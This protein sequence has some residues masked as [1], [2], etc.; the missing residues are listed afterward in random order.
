MTTLQL[1]DLPSPPK[2]KTG[3][4]WT[5]ISQCPSISGN[6]K[7]DWPRITIVTP[8]YNQGQYIEE[9]IRSVLLQNYPNLEYLVIDG[10]STDGTLQILKK[11]DSFIRWI[12][13][14]DKGQTD[15]INKG[16]KMAT[17]EIMAY[18]NSDDLYEPNA[19]INIAAFFG[20]REEIAMIYGDIIHINEKSGFIEFHRTGKVDIRKYLMWDFYLP[21][22]SVFFRKRVIDT[23]GYFDE[24]LHLAMDYDYWLKIILNFETWYVPETLSRAR[25]YPQA[26]SSFLDYMYHD[27]R[28]A[29]LDSIFKKYD[30]EPYRKNVF[31]Y[32]YFSG[33]L[34]FMKRHHIREAIKNFRIA[35]NI[36]SRYIIHPYLYWGIIE[37]IIGEKNAHGFKPRLKKI[38]DKIL[39]IESYNIIR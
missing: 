18:L 21:Q 12:S 1:S 19:L 17:G 30:F 39:H 16:L 9:T 6:E 14:P 27:E 23:L 8:S 10:N 20:Q 32:A 2:G 28:L 15:A 5:E 4:P 37:M 11:Y 26:K 33:A 31:S 22:P 35:L 34:M 25:L 7:F 38:L 3:W 36:D 24:K 29:I 13:E